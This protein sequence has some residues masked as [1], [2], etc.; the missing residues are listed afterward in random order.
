MK[1]FFCCVEK[2]PRACFAAGIVKVVKGKARGEGQNGT[3]NEN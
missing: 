1:L 3:K 2:S